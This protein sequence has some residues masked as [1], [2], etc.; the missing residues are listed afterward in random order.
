MI[1][2]FYND[3][4]SLGLK[5]PVTSIHKATGFN[6]GTVSMY[7]NRKD[8]PSENFIKAFYN[9]FGE[10]LKNANHKPLQT[11]GGVLPDNKDQVIFL[12]A[13]ANE[14]LLKDVEANSKILGELRE[15]VEDNFA[16]LS[17]V[18]LAVARILLNQEKGSLR[19]LSKRELADLLLI[20]GKL[21]KAA[22]DV[23]NEKAETDSK[24]SK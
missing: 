2:R 15:M 4:E 5:N 11:N 20:A 21:D 3:L 24:N 16:L 10:S 23:L 7:L 8:E 14:R 9:K 13:Q 12:L 22:A 19:V 17:S 6:K 18:R 1:D